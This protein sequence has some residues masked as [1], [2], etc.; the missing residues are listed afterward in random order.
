MNLK[1]ITSRLTLFFSTASTF[2]LLVVGL[3]V[4]SLVESHFEEQDLMELHGKL[5]LVR[6]TLAKV[7]TL[8][9][10]A[11]VPQ[12][13][14]D[15]LIGHPDLSVAILGPDHRILFT[16]PS[17]AF[18]T[19]LLEQPSS[20]DLSGEA[21]LVVWEQRGQ[22]YRGISANAD[23]GIAGQP[24]S[25]TVALAINIE[26][27]QA[28]M[29]AF[30]NNLWMAITAGI[31]LTIVLGWVAARRG[32]APVRQM[33]DVA[34]GI[35]ASHL[36]DRLSSNSVP[37]ELA[38]L[39]IAFNEMLARLEGSFQ[40]LSDFSSDLA[41]ELRTPISNLMTQTQV[42][43][44]KGRSADEYREVLYSNLEEYERLARMIADMLFLAKADNG[45][46]IPSSE[47]VDLA[48]E[49]RELFG[50]YEA[51]ADEQGIS[52]IVTGKGTVRGDRLMLR[53][54]LSNLLSNTIRHTSHGGSIKVFIDHS[55]SG[56][57]NLV[58]ENVG[59]T[60]PTEHLSR[61]F[62]RFYR[63]DPSRQKASDGA[64]LGLAI[65]KSII[66]AHQGNIQVF[67]SNGLTR[68]EITFPNV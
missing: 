21:R 8:S 66:E 12:S 49:V 17:A 65:T 10:L 54:A 26:H 24:S 37:P 64:G 57:T 45:L 52:L 3:L 27:H 2:V 28:F 30:H 33:A 5:E 58:I 23:T 48:K 63:V 32:L 67:S 31:L 1:S 18:A 14:S 47:T 46:I 6:H 34:K 62:D 50:F 15:A 56:E 35:S 22:I 41:H 53:R 68:F 29:K 13:L 20:K 9:D 42:A 40:R 38:N 44:S 39:A 11:T 36:S 16:T 25:A 7:R 60:I 61:L 19:Y 51:I 59:E 55:K 43:L 4:G